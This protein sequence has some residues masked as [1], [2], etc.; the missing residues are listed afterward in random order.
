L[1]PLR[2]E[3][4]TELTPY[5]T[6][7][8]IVANVAVWVYLQGAG[9]REELLVASVCRYGLIPAELRGAGGLVELAP[10]LGCRLGGLTWQT[11]FTSMFLHGSWVHLISNM[12]FLWLF[13]NNIEDSMGHLRFLVF[14][15]LVGLAAAAAHVWSAPDS[16]IPTIG[17]SGA[18]SGV[19]GAYLLLYPRVR[20][21][22]LFIFV[23]FIRIIPVS[24]WFV[25]AY[26]FFIQLL[27]GMTTPA[28]GGGVAFWAHVGGFVAGLLLIKFFENPR[29]VQAKRRHIRLRPEE[30]E[31]RGWF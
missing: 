5:V 14:Y 22:T 2:D 17:A 9:L 3:N 19:M 1:F 13:G 31:R 24:A 15:V 21:H 6:V 25:L 16:P 18:V 8:L 28:L 12:W 26:W 27:S 10:G 7:A 29:L 4:P 30:I 20:I 23:F 11:F